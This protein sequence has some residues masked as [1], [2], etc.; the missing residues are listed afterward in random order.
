MPKKEKPPKLSLFEKLLA[1]LGK[2]YWGMTDHELELLASRFKI[3]EYVERIGGEGV[4][5]LAL[6]KVSR[7]KQLNNRFLEIS[8]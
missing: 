2:N 7:K 8:L 4:S 1:L 6:T 3:G 5:F